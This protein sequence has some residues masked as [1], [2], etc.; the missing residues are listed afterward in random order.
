MIIRLRPGEK[1]TIGFAD[2]DHNPEDGEFEVHFDTVEHKDRI[3]VKETAHLPGSVKGGA[4]E[5]LYEEHFTNPEED[6]DAGTQKEI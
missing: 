1:L 4:G 5:I 6:A 2:D 3:V